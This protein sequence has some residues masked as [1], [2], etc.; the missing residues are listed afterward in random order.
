[1]SALAQEFA[2]VR[3]NT[4]MPRGRAISLCVALVVCSS[5][6][7][8]QGPV[9]MS[10]AQRGMSVEDSC[11]GDSVL[12]EYQ[13]ARYRPVVDFLEYLKRQQPATV[14][15]AGFDPTKGR[16][17]SVD[18]VLSFIAP[19]GLTVTDANDSGVREYTPAALRRALARRTSRAFGT[20]VHL[21]YIYG[22][23]HVGSELT[24][25]TLPD[26]VLVCMSDWY[27]LTFFRR[28]PRLLLRRIGYVMDETE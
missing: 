10:S 9:A 27:R 1:V 28:G 11:G 2:R 8:G 16:M 26:G 17:P 5:R 24:Y 15:V 13:P 21:G 3:A 14:G 23:S 18:T 7:C 6:V 19:E 25:R 12:G 22:Q 4:T 20:F